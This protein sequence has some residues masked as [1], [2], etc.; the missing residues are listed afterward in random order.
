MVC[1]GVGPS[2]RRFLCFSPPAPFPVDQL[3]CCW[4][5]S[6]IGSLA[7]LMLL[8][9]YRCLLLPLWNSVGM[10]LWALMVEEVIGG[11]EWLKF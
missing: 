3:R 5:L 6:R 9:L 4:V 11:M 1:G 10:L 7:L 8:L 2:N